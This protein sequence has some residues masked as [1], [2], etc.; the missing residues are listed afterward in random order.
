MCLRDDIFSEKK[1]KKKFSLKHIYEMTR[2][3]CKYFKRLTGQ[4]PNG[5]RNGG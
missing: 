3:L 2:Y 4:T 1:R 5:W